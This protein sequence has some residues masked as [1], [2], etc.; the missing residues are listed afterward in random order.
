MAEQKER[1][2]LLR[3]GFLLAMALSA[4]LTGRAQAASFD[5]GK[6]SNLLEKTVCTD[7]QLSDYDE[8]ISHAFTT[9]LAPLSPAGRDDL[10]KGQRQ[11]LRYVQTV[12]S[13][14]AE[15]LAGSGQQRA[16]ECLHGAYL[17]RQDQLQRASVRGGH[18]IIAQVDQFLAYPDPPDASNTLAGLHPGF[19]ST[20]ISYPQIDDPADASQ[21]AF[22]GAVLAWL[23]SVGGSDN[24]TAPQ[25]DDMT[26]SYE[27]LM[28][29]SQLISVLLEANDLPHDAD[30]T[31]AAINNINWLLR[32]KR[33]LQDNDVFNRKRPW[34]PALKTWVKQ[35]L[36]DN[37]KACRCLELGRP[38][39]DGLI[40]KS[41]SADN[42]LLTKEGL[43]VQFRPGELGGSAAGAPRVIIPWRKLKP[44]LATERVV[45]LPPK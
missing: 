32:Q 10:R 27:V 36:R 41:L 12:C 33:A 4:A 11:W 23:K 17:N 5:C 3:T 31:T 40:G 28:A 7:P 24:P 38:G 6:A 15:T 29:N 37:N 30:H 20:E 21:K 45:G 26:L 18:Y 42:W 14:D 19:A 44:Y 35:A 8:G 43:V 13:V 16:V 34:K 9:A 22:N 2:I 1:L 25:N 39:V